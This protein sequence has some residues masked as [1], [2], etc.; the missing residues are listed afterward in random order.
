AVA[1]AGEETVHLVGRKPGEEFVGLL[2]LDPSGWLGP[3][4]A[5]LGGFLGLSATLSPPGFY[6]D[7]LGLD[8]HRLEV[9]RVASGFAREHCRVLVAPRVS[10][11][12]RD[13]AAHA[14]P[15]AALLQSCIEAV[16]GNTAVYFPSFEMLRDITARWSIEDR[17]VLAQEPSMSE[18]RRLDWLRRIGAGGPP[19]VLAAV[20]GGI[21]AEGIDLP[22]GALDAVLVAGPAL[23][24]VGMERDLLRN[25]YEDRYGEGFR[26]ASLVPGITRVVQAAGRLIRRPEDRGVIVL[27]GRRF[28]WRETSSLF[29]TEWEVEVP[30]DPAA[31]I[32]AFWRS[33]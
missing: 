9:L 11:V 18:Q 8:P 2:C 5:E 15:T 14:E 6:R 21:F 12:Y 16:P 3:R 23:P 7:L 4:I 26:Y 17:E 19:L 20:L 24:P 28:R 33:T 29:P 25:Y 10:T 1:S 32:S 13:R 31:A 22:P 27:V 30:D